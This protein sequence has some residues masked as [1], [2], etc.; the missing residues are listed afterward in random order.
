M[1][2]QRTAVS[3]SRPTP[4]PG[5]LQPAGSWPD[6]PGQP[7]FPVAVVQ[8][9]PEA[10]WLPRSFGDLS[11]RSDP[12]LNLRLDPLS[13][14][15]RSPLP[16]RPSRDTAMPGWSLLSREAYPQAYRD[17]KQ[18]REAKASGS[19]APGAGAP[20]PGALSAAER[21][22]LDRIALG[23]GTSDEKARSR[24]FASGYDVP[25]AYGAYAAPD[26]PLT[27]MTLDE[28]DRLQTAMLRHPDNTSTSSASGKYQFT[29]TT[30]RDLRRQMGL[31]GDELF[32]PELQERLAMRLLRRRGYERFLAGKISQDEFQDELS[33]EWA[34]VARPSTG[35]SYHEQPTGTSTSEIQP[36]L[37][38]LRSR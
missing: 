27:Q 17:W 35:K 15:T 9:R 29:R 28:L 16:S 2:G 10:A 22:L 25:L 8:P 5:L 13:P 36:V 1:A 14:A 24:N 20:R 6:R 12:K 26:K 31:K 3:T 38:R 7:V 21:A 18:A 33:Q 4:V 37:E 23:E 19:A 30:M 34:S 11:P 32:S